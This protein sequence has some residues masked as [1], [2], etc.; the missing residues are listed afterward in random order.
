MLIKSEPDVYEKLHHLA[1]MATDDILE[2]A[3]NSKAAARVLGPSSSPFDGAEGT[4][5]YR[6]GAT[7]YSGIYRASMP[8]GKKISLFR[9]M[10]TDHCAYDCHYCPNSYWVPRERFGFKV[11]ELAALFADVHRRHMVEGLFLSS[12]IF[13]SPDATM[14]RLLDV[15]EAV[16]TRHG[17]QGYVHLKVMPGTSAQYLEAAQRLGTRLS[18]NIE[19]PSALHLNRVSGMKRFDEDILQPI[20]TIHQLLERRYGGAVGQATQLVV[21]TAD[22]TDRDIYQLQ[23]KLYGQWNFKRIYYAPFRPVQFTPLEEHEPTP[24]V[25]AHRLNQLDWLL[26]VYRYTTGE[27]D[28][29]FDE[30]GGLDQQAD[31]KLAIASKQADRFPMDVNS[32]PQEELVRVP[33]IGP[34]AAQRIVQQRRQHSITRWQEL[35]AMGAVVKRALPFIVFSGHRPVQAVQGRLPMLQALS[36]DPPAIAA[37]DEPV[38]ARKIVARFHQAF[39]AQGCAGCPLNQAT[40]GQHSATATAGRVPSGAVA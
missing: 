38:P 21:G 12:G 40:C 17:F 10:L 2:E 34:V 20:D 24:M 5:P 28:T 30:A 23:Q 15:V 16:R 19:S 33:G 9:V 27:M 3:P 1:G 26:R 36:L 25:R 35:Q 8:N 32:A 13:N 39:A 7:P 31:P 22:E 11:D 14:E 37:K 4:G 6:G 29:A 18:V